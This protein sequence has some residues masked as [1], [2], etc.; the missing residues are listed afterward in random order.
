M[1]QLRIQFSLLNI[2]L[3]IYNFINYDTLA[4]T[5]FSTLFVSEEWGFASFSKLMINQEITSTIANFKDLVGKRRRR[6][7]H[8]NDSV[9]THHFLGGF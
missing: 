3:K 4:M 6:K 2:T 7:T 8:F 9:I 5:I 1:E